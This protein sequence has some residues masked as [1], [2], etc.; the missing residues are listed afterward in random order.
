[1]GSFSGLLP[2]F[3]VPFW[4]PFWVT[5]G[6]L[7]ILFCYSRIFGYNFFLVKFGFLKNNPDFLGIDFSM[8]LKTLWNVACRALV[9]YFLHSDLTY[10]CGKE[11]Q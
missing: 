3:W 9:S 8:L 6:F 7:G 11:W 5:S 1:M 10:S 2:D 4:V